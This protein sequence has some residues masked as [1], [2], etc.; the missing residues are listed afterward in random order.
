MKQSE[1]LATEIEKVIAILTPYEADL[2]RI[3]RQHEFGKAEVIVK[4]GQIQVLHFSET[5]QLSKSGGLELDSSIVVA[6]GG[7]DAIINKLLDL[8]KDGRK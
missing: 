6:P 5:T 2:I 4:K 3:L 1:K 8:A 7:E